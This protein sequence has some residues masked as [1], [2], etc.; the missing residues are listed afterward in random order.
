MDV[1]KPSGRFLAA[2]RS[3]GNASRREDLDASALLSIA[4]STEEDRIKY[5]CANNV[6]W[7]QRVE[8]SRASRTRENRRPRVS[9]FTPYRSSS[10]TPSK[11]PV[12]ER[13][14]YLGQ[15]GGGGRAPVNKVMPPLR[16]DGRPAVPRRL[17][18]VPGR[19]DWRKMK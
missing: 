6:L 2:L 4:A 12:N 9:E 16:P 17:R 10:T 14:L 19:P 5:T 3:A 18:R 8:R 13:G 1:I 15:D 7:Q 11:T